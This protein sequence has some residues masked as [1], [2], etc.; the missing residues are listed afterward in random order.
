[1]WTDKVD[2]QNGPKDVDGKKWTEKIGQR[3]KRFAMF[4]AVY[5]SWFRS[6][7]IRIPFILPDNSVNQKR[8]MQS[9][10]IGFSDL[11]KSSNGWPN[12]PAQM[13][14]EESASL[15]DFHEMIEF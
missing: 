12:R 1:M 9:L 7:K 3:L 11:S 5:C 2:G 13:R 14:V 6:L 8:V 15:V 4:A 10:E